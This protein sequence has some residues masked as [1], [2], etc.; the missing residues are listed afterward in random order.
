MVVLKTGDNRA[1]HGEC[2]NSLVIYIFFASSKEKPHIIFF[3]P[4]TKTVRELNERVTK[5]TN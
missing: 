3:K 2:H 4:M 1:S 5:G